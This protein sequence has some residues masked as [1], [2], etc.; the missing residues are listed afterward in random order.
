MI[1]AAS[2]AQA[3]TENTIPI[4]RRREMYRPSIGSGQSKVASV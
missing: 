3:T 2:A 4:R 1:H